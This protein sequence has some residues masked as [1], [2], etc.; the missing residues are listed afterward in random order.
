MPWYSFTW[1]L[2][3]AGTRRIDRQFGAI[4][5]TK[6]ARPTLFCNHAAG[7][8]VPRISSRIG[9]HVISFCVNDDSRSAI[10]EKRMAISGKV[11]IL[12]GES[13]LRLT[14]G[15]NGEVG[16][17]TGMVT[18]GILK[19]VL[20]PVWIEMWTCRC[21]VRCLALGVLMEVYRVLAWRQIFEI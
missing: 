21:E 18:L 14:V 5:L 19:A 7:N 3:A 12:V 4:Y 6:N 1:R 11:Y 16:H 9:L 10:A 17:V 20:L 2:A 13:D 8:P 15:T